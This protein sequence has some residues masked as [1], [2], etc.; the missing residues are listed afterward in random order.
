[1]NDLDAVAKAQDP[2]DQFGGGGDPQGHA[3][4]SI[5]L[6]ND[7]LAGVPGPVLRPGRGG[8]VEEE[9]HG[10][11]VA[12]AHD[13][14]GILDVSIEVEVEGELVGMIGEGAAS[15]TLDRKEADLLAQMAVPDEL[16]GAAG[17]PEPVRIDLPAGRGVPR[18]GEVA[19]LHLPPSV[20]GVRE[21]VDRLPV[22][23]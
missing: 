18:G 20:D 15:D 11:R 3:Q 14:Q 13:A 17:V 2:A 22:P 23:R 8:L 12:P 16:A 19:H 7:L 10:D 1:M 9:F 21:L 5:L 4:S 6:P